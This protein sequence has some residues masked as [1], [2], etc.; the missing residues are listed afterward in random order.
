MDHLWMSKEGKLAP[1]RTGP[2]LTSG[3]GLSGMSSCKHRGIYI[4]ASLC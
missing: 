4:A 2:L 1:L 3:A